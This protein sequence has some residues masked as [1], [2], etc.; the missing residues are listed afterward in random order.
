MGFS[1]FQR[2]LFQNKTGG[3]HIKEGFDEPRTIIMIGTSL[4]GKKELN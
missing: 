3:K 2:N 1:K 4:L